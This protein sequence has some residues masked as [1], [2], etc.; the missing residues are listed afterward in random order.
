MEYKA[1]GTG[2]RYAAGEVVKAANVLPSNMTLYAEWDYDAEPTVTA[3]DHNTFTASAPLA[4]K[5][6]ISK[7]QTTKPDS[8]TTGWST[9][10][11]QD[12]S[13]ST[14]ETYYVWVQDA[15]GKISS[16]YATI[17]N[18]EI[19][20]M[21][22][23]GTTL[24]VKADNATT[25]TT[26]VSGNYVLDT[27][28]V[29]PTG[30]LDTGYN[31]LVIKKGT[32]T[33]TNGSEQVI[34]SDTVFITSASNN[35]LT[36]N[37]QTLDSGIYGTS[38]SSNEFV[39][40]TN[41][42][43]SYSYSL[44]GVYPTGT[45]ISGR[46]IS[47]PANTPA[48]TYEIEVIATDNNSG[49]TATAT[50]TITINKKALT[51][52]ANDQTIIY[53]NSVTSDPLYCTVTD[54]ALVS[55][56]QIT[57]ITLTP[58]TSDI[59]ESGLITPSAAVIKDLSNN[60]VTSNYEITYD[61]GL[62]KIRNASINFNSTGGT[63]VGGYFY[64]RKGVS[65]ISNDGLYATTYTSAPPIPTKLGFTLKGWYT[66]ETGG[67]K[68]KNSD[69]SFTGT[70]VTGYVTSNAWDV[71]EDKTI[72]AQWEADSLNFDNQTLNSVTYGTDYTSNS[73]EGASNGTG[74]Y[75]YSLRSGYPENT[76]IDSTNRTISMPANTP[77]GTY[78]II[79]AATD[80]VSGAITPAT[81]TIVVNPKPVSVAWD[82]VT[83]IYDG[84]VHSTTATIDTGI[85]G[86]YMSLDLDGLNSI[87]N[88]GTSE[89]TASCLVATSSCSNYT[90]SGTTNTLEVVP[91]T[92]TVTAANKSR[93]YS[94]ANP[95]LTYTYSNQATG[96]TPG[97]TGT[98]STNATTSSNIGS[99]TISK[100]T[101][102]LANGSGGFLASNYT[103]SFTGATLT[104]TRKPIA[105]TGTCTY[106]VYD[107]SPK[108]LASGAS[109]ATY[110]ANNTQTN[111]GASNYVI[112]VT[113]A[114]NYA[115]T[116]GSYSAKTVSCNIQKAALPAPS[117]SATLNNS[118]GSSRI[119]AD[120]TKA[121]KIRYRIRITTNSGTTTYTDFA[122]YNG[123]DYTYN[124]SFLLASNYKNRNI[125]VEAQAL[126]STN[127]NYNAE[128]AVGTSSV[129]NVV[130]I[131]VEDPLNNVPDEEYPTYLT[132][133]AYKFVGTSAT[134]TARCR[135]K[136]NYFAKWK[137]KQ[138]LTDN[139]WYDFST[140]PVSSQNISNS[141]TFTVQNMEYNLGAFC[142]GCD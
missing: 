91:R 113:P 120:S 43:G 27:T 110:S 33:I 131:I 51:I 52:K 107:G 2:T 61:D 45:T 116:D 78:N 125:Y 59:T 75:S 109:H 73:F 130:Q 53:G 124:I 92:L 46:I 119:I 114:A 136:C 104:V 30:A 67:T 66:A 105:T 123:T 100:N 88:V 65:G 108:T 14:K 139:T 48:G 16:K 32:S 63:P 74:S 111:V 126:N 128:S 60:P 5:Y 135:A 72:Y 6:L 94:D 18:Y 47:M 79:V 7:T 23:T 106:P 56:D 41:G 62:L 12:S 132:G 140:C 122:T 26:I 8:S 54:G 96:E 64:T 49:A 82:V 103:M 93:Y 99:Y 15:D 28:S 133:N 42:T 134:I 117:V 40:A 44:A 115:F 86:E 71:T 95:E 22:G 20:L 36:F 11:T 38:Y 34:S 98:L 141:C 101:L 118:S 68:I 76:T 58:S 83:W 24:S 17:T 81:M 77:A 137:K 13:I 121:Q 142:S 85:T 29:Y 31:G 19:T 129:I 70:A 37:D 4:S 112:T 97:F 55:N 50:M 9:T 21:P 69:F 138:S 39:G 57:G 127:I 80:T 102:A 84:N 35:M 3:E 10:T 87:T 89:L 25:G 90:L 1:D